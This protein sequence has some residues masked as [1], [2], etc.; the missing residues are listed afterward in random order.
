MYWSVM[1]RCNVMICYDVF[2]N[3]ATD[4]LFPKSIYLTGS[5]AYSGALYGSMR[6]LT[7]AVRSHAPTEARYT[8]P[9]AQS[10]TLTGHAPDSGEHLAGNGLNSLSWVLP[11]PSSAVLPNPPIVRR[12]VLVPAPTTAR[13]TGTCALSCGLYGPLRLLWR[14]VLAPAPAEARCILAVLVA[15]ACSR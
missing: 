10:G 4:E 15:Q 3:D 6:L 7:L 2:C 5:C 12:N 1:T 9:R 13:C 8:S 14:T 11:L